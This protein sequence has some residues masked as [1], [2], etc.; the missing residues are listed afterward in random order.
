MTRV[1]AYLFKNSLKMILKLLESP[2]LDEAAKA[3]IKTEIT[4]MLQV[5]DRFSMK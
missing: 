5:L 1:D 4:V 2:S 3:K